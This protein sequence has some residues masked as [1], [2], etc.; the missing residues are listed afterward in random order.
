MASIDKSSSSATNVIRI[1]DYLKKLQQPCFLD[2][3]G[4]SDYLP[5]FI[6]VKIG[7]QDFGIRDNETADE[8]I[9]R[10]ALEKKNQVI[11]P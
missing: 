2:D 11:R 1:P 10:L 7:R 3:D 5:T 9:T 4:P 6:T 8:A